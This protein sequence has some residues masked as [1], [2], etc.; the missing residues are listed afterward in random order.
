VF[1]RSVFF[2]AGALAQD[3]RQIEPP[4][5][6][7]GS[8]RWEQYRQSSYAVLAK[9]EAEAAMQLTIRL[10]LTGVPPPIPAYSTT[11]YHPCKPGSAGV[12]FAVV[13]IPLVQ[14]IRGQNAVPPPWG[15][16]WER[17]P[18]HGV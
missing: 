6:F 2:E 8:Y 9:R 3:S 12:G 14:Q 1:T 4:H 7:V 17:G 11:P 18:Q 16:G 10:I 5:E 13:G 15:S